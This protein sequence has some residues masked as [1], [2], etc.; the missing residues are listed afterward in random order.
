MDNLIQALTELA[1]KMNSPM[2]VFVYLIL[3]G[4]FVLIYF[5]DRTI[6]KISDAQQRTAV[7]LAR[8][9]ELLNILV[10]DGMDRENP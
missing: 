3:I 1:K 7:Q 5:K 2:E 9:A 10:R 4:L 6:R 8:V